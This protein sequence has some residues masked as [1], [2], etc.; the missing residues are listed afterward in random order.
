M[1]QAPGN[2][3]LRRVT[4]EAVLDA[5][6]DQPTDWVAQPSPLGARVGKALRERLGEAPI[7]FSRQPGI[8]VRQ[9]AWPP[10][11]VADRDPAAPERFRIL[12]PS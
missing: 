3:V 10:I 6:T 2:D 9:S 4:S 1:L 12:H 7:R 8:S 11:Q 5:L